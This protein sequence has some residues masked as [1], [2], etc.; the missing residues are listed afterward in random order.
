[1]PVNSEKY[2]T[3]EQSPPRPIKDY[4]GDS[5]KKMAVLF[6]DIVG[7]S[8]F[9][10][11]HGDI[12]GRKMLK[13]HQD[14]A[15]PGI[16]DFGGAVVKML[17]DSVMAYFLDPKDALKSAIKIQ[18]NFWS[19]NKNKPDKDQIH[20][21]LCIHYGEGIVDEGDIFGDVVNMAAKFLPLASG[22]EIIVSKE[23]HE[24]IERTPHISFNPFNTP[25]PSKV[26]KGLTLFKVIWNNEIEYDPTMKTLVHLRPLWSLG[27]KNFENLWKKMIS[28]RNRFWT[29]RTVEKEQFDAEKSIS[30]IVKEPSFALEI[31]RGVINFLRTN[32]GQDASLYV[33][34]Q[35]IIAQGAFIRTGR[36]IVEDIKI[37]WNELAPGEIYASKTF[38][39]TIENTSPGKIT[40][41]MNNP[42][43]IGFYKIFDNGSSNHDD[44]MF[45]YQTALIQGEYAPCF[46]C[47]SRSHHT[48]MCPSK[49][50]TEHTNSIEKLGYMTI[51]A[52]NTCFF[53][54]LQDSRNCVDF[55][56]GISGD[57]SSLCAHNAFY[58]LKS[59]FQL[60]L[61]MALWNN[62]ENSW[63]RIRDNREERDRGGLLWIGLDCIRV[64][65]LGQ[66]ESIL[67]KEMARRDKDYKPLCLTGIFYIE[68]NN[69]ARAVTALKKA[70][71][72]AIK[73]PE[74]IYILFLLFRIYSLSNDLVKAR[75]MLKKIVKFDP[76]CVEAV[77]QDII[78]KFNIGDKRSAVEHLV[79][80]VKKSKEYYIIALIDP[81]LSNF[82]KLISKKFEDLFFEAREMA[83]KIIPLSKE[84]FSSLEKLMGK[85][86]EEIIDA[87]SK[88]E[89]IDSLFNSNSYFGYLDVIHY[90]KV[91]LNLGKR[92]TQGRGM[93]LYRLE[94]DIGQRI[95]RCEKYLQLLPQGMLT[96]SAYSDLK[97][98]KRKMEGISRQV[99]QNGVFEF[100]KML[101]VLKN[102]VKEMADLE[103]KIKRVDT[104]VQL[105]SF[106]I[107]FLKKNLLF[108]S[109]NLAVSLILLPIMIH[110]LNFIMPNLELSTQGIWH[111]QKILIILGGITGIILSSLTS[112]DKQT[113]QQ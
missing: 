93:H 28:G 53:Q 76:M 3:F 66:A 26:L 33:P 39:D 51:N 7:S 48:T 72:L 46:Y 77:Y 57:S 103:M 44:K 38:L 8:N 50:I 86:S 109:I 2:K 15:S 61:F 5:I 74:K 42:A 59:V 71:D 60:R 90:G 37:N 13:L 58:E 30:L 81:E 16:T 101:E 83:E 27:K 49:M 22:D 69:Y 84:E 99:K 32:M 79:K 21:R 92:I 82:S 104:I 31:V 14:I 102:C 63:N 94:Q 85:D 41:D 54:Y 65:N 25:K 107:N 111:F 98:M 36:I 108:Q 9:F 68:K 56:T 75:E 64:G 113:K 100:Q 87:R 18:Q 73:T 105:L 19:F 4:S 52:V 10:K 11:A 62:S 29:A 47:G 45:R 88:I 12:A 78:L 89:K 1:M 40:C 96:Q 112:Q 110:Y 20:I 6:T 106:G 23:L 97:I 55:S 70:L 95:Q 35:M 17:G 24:N 67:E 80:L 91:I 34:V 43:G